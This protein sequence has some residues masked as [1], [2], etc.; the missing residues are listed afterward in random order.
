[1]KTI[2]T[3]ELYLKLESGNPA[4]FDVRGDVDFEK[5]HIPGAL[6]APLGSLCF[7]VRDVMNQDSFIT[8]YSQG[9]DCGL[10][11]EAAERLENLGMKNV[12]LYEE[13]LDGWRAAGHEVKASVNAKVHAHGEFIECRSIV[14]DWETAYGG[15]FKTTSQEVGGAGG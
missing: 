14:V 15:A 1:M 6:T 3:N 9:K 4:V 12:H 13:G 8:V 5:G 11:R 7:R 2:N 10:A